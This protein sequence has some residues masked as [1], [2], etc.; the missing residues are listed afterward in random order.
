MSILGNRSDTGN[1]LAAFGVPPGLPELVDTPE[2]E[3]QRARLARSR[4]QGFTIELLDALTP[5][6][7]VVATDIT[8]TTGQFTLDASKTIPEGGQFTLRDALWN[9]P[10]VPESPYDFLTKL[11]RVW[12]HV[13]PHGED[14]TQTWALVTHMLTAISE[15]HYAGYR[16]WDVRTHSMLKW[17]DQD[18]PESV[19]TVSAGTP[20][21]V[22]LTLQLM[23][24]G[25]PTQGVQDIPGTVR[26]DRV[27]EVGASRLQVCN[28][29][30]TS[31]G[32]RSLIPDGM[33]VPRSR[34][35]EEST[36][37]EHTWRSG[38]DCVFSD[39][40]SV[41][42]DTDDIPNKVIVVAGG[43]DD[44]PALIGTAIDDDPSSPWSTNVPDPAN[45]IMGVGRVIARKRTSSETTTQQTADTQAAYFLKQYRP[46]A[47][48]NLE[49]LLGP[50]Q[51]RDDIRIEYIYPPTGQVYWSGRW[52]TGAITYHLVVENQPF[53]VLDCYLEGD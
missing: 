6:W 41:S 19:I 2:I 9:V 22:F 16:W 12:A 21:S 24:C 38:V 8:V 49:A 35:M 47:Q 15:Q 20:V 29:V 28:D 17:A 46:T 23:A 11:V 39:R 13:T 36:G 18:I 14:V 48:L 53:M 45:G 52:E 37:V 25:L 27:W 5:G 31:A 32:Y 43:R 44:E 40:I 50:I 4:V 34:P 10:W 7:P 26:N 3:M 1:Q 51:L 42:L 30:L 33:G